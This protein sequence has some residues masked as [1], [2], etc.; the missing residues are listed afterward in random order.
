MTDPRGWRVYG[1]HSYI[2]L[3][4]LIHESR[5]CGSMMVWKN[6]GVG[7]ARSTWLP[8]LRLD[9]NTLF[10][11]NAECFVLNAHTQTH[12]QIHTFTH[13]H[14]CTHAHIH[15]YTHTCTYTHSLSL[16]HTHTHTHTCHTQY[17]YIHDACK[18]HVTNELLQFEHFRYCP[19]AVDSTPFYTIITKSAKSDTKASDSAGAGAES[20]FGAAGVD[21]VWD[22]VED[23]YLEGPAFSTSAKQTMEEAEESLAE[24]R[25]WSG[26]SMKR[27]LWSEKSMNKAEAQGNANPN[28]MQLGENFWMDRGPQYQGHC[29]GEYFT[30]PSKHCRSFPLFL[31]PSLSLYAGK[32]IWS[33]G[34][35]L[36]PARV[37]AHTHFLSLF[38]GFLSLVAFLSLPCALSRVCALFQSLS[39]SLTR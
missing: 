10:V 32:L 21:Y 29:V 27:G 25:L 19:S 36:S 16:T 5:W 18:H 30:S 24:L 7:A 8:G 39:L 6:D 3:T 26:K 13:I 17:I 2:S 38:S 31:F 11:L 33:H 23:V 9:S 1:T 37:H 34:R 4:W 15:A 28:W 20:N 12:A 22:I 35:G 14:T